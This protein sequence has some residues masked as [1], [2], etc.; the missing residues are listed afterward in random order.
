MEFKG[1]KGEWKV[2]GD[3]IW[4]NE[5]NA[6]TITIDFID[7]NGVDCIDVYEGANGSEEEL[8][9]NAKLIAAAPELLEFAIEMVKRYPVSPWITEQGKKAIKKALT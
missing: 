4:K 6:K 7:I 9:A 8:I 1:T 3:G 5:Y 2:S